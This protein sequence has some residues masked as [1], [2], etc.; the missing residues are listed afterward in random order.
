MLAGALVTQGLLC[1]LPIQVLGMINKFSVCWNA[2]GAVTLIILL[3]T[4]APRHQTAKFVFTNFDSDAAGHYKNDGR[5][6]EALLRPS[7]LQTAFLRSLSI[8]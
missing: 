7:V 5:V 1:L 6:L 4:V 2:L 3:P 8:C